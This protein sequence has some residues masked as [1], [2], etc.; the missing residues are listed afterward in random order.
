MK[1]FFLLLTAASAFV[2][3]AYGQPTVPAAPASCNASICTTN[4]TID[5]C[6][7][8]SNTVVSTFTGKQLF[9]NNGNAG[10]SAG[11]VWR[12]R[13]MATVSGNTIN[14]VVTVDAISNAVL[15]NLDDDAA[16]DQSNASISSFFAPRI[17]P[18]QNLN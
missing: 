2:V 12:Y 11:S 18:H 13:N 15:D 8:G 5:V 6:P 3:S 1:Q 17:G 16:V 4:S 14:A 9:T 10:L 7:P